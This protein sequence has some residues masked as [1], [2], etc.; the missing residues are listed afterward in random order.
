MKNYLSEVKNYP[1]S[2]NEVIR[3]RSTV[4][5]FVKP[6]QLIRY[7]GL[8]RLLSAEIFIKHEN[9]N[10][11]GTFK[12]RGGINLM[13][14]L[15]LCNISGVITFST[16][17]HGLSVATS[18]KWFGLDAVVVVPEHNNP[19]KNR[20]IIETGAE[21]IEA[22]KTFEDASLTVERL[23]RER[24]LYYVH[25]ADEPHL[26][27]G[28]GTEFLEILEDVP[29]LD[30]ML[31]PLGAGSEAAA[32]ITVLNTIRP[33]AEVFAVQAQNS[34]AAYRSWKTK[35]LSTGANTTFAGGFATGKAYE[36]TF[37]IYCDGLRDFI[38]LSEDE[39]YQ[40][41]G[42]AY[43]YTQNLVEGAGGST[44][45]AALKLKDRI[46][47]KKV[48]LQ[49]SGCNASTEEVEKAITNSVFRRGIDL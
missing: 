49:M 17:N 18:A 11:T 13:Q 34:P 42:M 30:M 47:G 36:T 12:I 48:V 20:K 4:S 31:V 19:A 3:A 32:A 45:M 16:G 25:P 9:H 41:I 6:T 37:N 24:D 35:T 7:E 14:H 27:N 38:L 43:Y 15:K 23:C 26:I 22:G 33:Q 46:K 5:S 1:I 44:L 10:P 8:S 39:I 40:S 28:V 29:D 21:L 2:L